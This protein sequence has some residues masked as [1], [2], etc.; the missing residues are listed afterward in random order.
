[1]KSAIYLT[2]LKCHQFLILFNM[3]LWL[4]WQETNLIKIRLDI[5]VSL[6]SSPIQEERRETEISSLILIRLARDDTAKCVFSDLLLF[7]GIFK[8]DKVNK[9][10]NHTQVPDM[11]SSSVILLDQFKYSMV[12]IRVRWVRLVA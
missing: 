9:K 6:R 11:E 7:Q 8:S 4:V 10:K 5:S 3:Y 2:Y 1:M 12:W